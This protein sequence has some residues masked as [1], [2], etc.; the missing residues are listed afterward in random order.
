M[1]TFSKIV[2]YQEFLLLGKSKHVIQRVTHGKLSK[3]FIIGS[4][5]NA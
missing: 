1:T 4:S 2:S 5:A 3:S